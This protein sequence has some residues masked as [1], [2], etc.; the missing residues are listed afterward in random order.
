MFVS[1]GVVNS[2]TKH[3][4]LVSNFTFAPQDINVTVGDTVEWQWTEGTHT[5]TSDSTSG[6]DV[7]NSPIS[8]SV[9]FFSVV[10]RTSGLHNYHCIPH[11]AFG[12]IGSI[13]AVMP[14][15]INETGQLPFQFSLSQNFPNPFNPSTMIM[16]NLPSAVFVTLK[17]Y[18]ALGKEVETLVN[19]NQNSGQHMEVFDIGKTGELSSGVYFY[20]LTAGGLVQTRKM[21]L[22]K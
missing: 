1:L 4:V 15:A 8:V 3:V 17:V 10:I 5:T 2:Q 6:V 7:W 20:R 13:T 14:T 16:Y 21:M 11:Q 18:N 12:M 19:Q 9:P 22:I